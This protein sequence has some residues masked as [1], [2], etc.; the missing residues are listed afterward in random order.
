MHLQCIN[1]CKLTHYTINTC[2]CASIVHVY[3]H[4]YTHMIGIQHTHVYMY[5]FYI[6]DAY[7]IQCTSFHCGHQLRGNNQDAYQ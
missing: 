2:V 3:V 5:E 4:T 1:A 7:R 6:T